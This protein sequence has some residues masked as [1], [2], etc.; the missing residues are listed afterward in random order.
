MNSERLGKEVA[1]SRRGFQTTD[2]STCTR[3]DVHLTL[4]FRPPCEG[5][6]RWLQSARLPQ[7]SVASESVLYSDSFS[8]FTRPYT[9]SP[10][11]LSKT[12][13]ARKIRL[14]NKKVTFIVGKI[15]WKVFKPKKNL[16]AVYISECSSRKV[17]T[18]CWI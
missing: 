14:G 7:D 1:W 13:G 18:F 15:K 6:G 5:G 9:S 2:L 10:S 4:H 11:E 17:L 3:F 8:R 12:R 16:A